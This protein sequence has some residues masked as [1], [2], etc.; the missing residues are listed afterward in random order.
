MYLSIE[1]DFL[2]KDK[3]IIGIFD[4]DNT[5]V[6]ERGR[7]FLDKAEKE[8]HVV[9]WYPKNPGDLPLNYILTVEYGMTKIYQ[10]GLT[11]QK[12]EKRLK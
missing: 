4:L 12:L 8:G 10:T 5:T 6:T 9:P 7:E 1:N 2:V 11:A 3:S